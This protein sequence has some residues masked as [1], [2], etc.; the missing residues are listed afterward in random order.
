MSG[1][2]PN[3]HVLKTPWQKMRGA[4]GVQKLGGNVLV[5][6]Y[7][8][9]GTRLFHT[10]FCPP[11]RI[12]GMD[13]VGRITFDEIVPPNRFVRIP[14]AK[15]VVEADPDTELDMAEIRRICNHF[16]LSV[17]DGWGGDP[18]FLMFACALRDA[19]AELDSSVDFANA[20]Y[21]E[22]MRIVDAAG[23]LLDAGMN[24][25]SLPVRIWKKAV[26][27]W[28]QVSTFEKVEYLLAAEYEAPWLRNHHPCARCS[29]KG[30]WR[31]VIVRTPVEAD[32]WRYNRPENYVP[33]CRRCAYEL[34][35]SVRIDIR[36]EIA[37][38]IWGARFEA[39]LRWHRARRAGTLPPDWNRV[40]YPLWPPAFGGE[41]WEE[42]SGHADH[43]AP[44]L[45]QIDD[46]KVERIRRVLAVP[47]KVMFR[48]QI[49]TN[50]ASQ[51]LLFS[52]ERIM[53]T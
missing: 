45:P 3:L 19:Y 47:Q 27:V 13:D 40:E 38:I 46:Q 15:V 28:R 9:A 6:P 23:F 10:F 41:T 52:K 44:A 29:E 18:Y 5:F 48:A 30:L 37:Q 7:R 22:R 49:C 17:L 39:L 43:A 26:S 42:G 25:T 11:L 31:Q 4:V 53:L 8:K 16:P 32:E 34:R 50:Q 20:S 2:K 1:V 24:H 36:Y 21:E 12:V 35:F 51:K 33:L 14:Q